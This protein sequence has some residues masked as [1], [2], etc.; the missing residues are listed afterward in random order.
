MSTYLDRHGHY[1]DSIVVR[2]L[3]VQSARKGDD[4]FGEATS[5]VALA[6][7]HTI[8]GEHTA[9]LQSLESA[10]RIVDDL[11]HKRGQASVLYHLAGLEMH[12]GNTAA[13]LDLYRRCLSRVREMEL[14]EALAWVH[15]RYGAA[16]RATEQYG[17]ALEHLREAKSFALRV[18]DQSALSA[19]LVEI[20]AVYRDLG[21]LATSSIYCGQALDIAESI[22]DLELTAQICTTLAAISKDRGEP[23][24][25]MTFARQAVDLCRNTRNVIG[26]AHARNVLGDIEFANGDAEEAALDW[27]QAAQL[28]EYVGNIPSAAAARAKLDNIPGDGVQV[29]AVRPYGT[30]DKNT[31]SITKAE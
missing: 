6:M 4:S 26:E 22:P 11:G 20:A 15:C 14:D 13:A 1:E 5:L 23:R 7:V 28:Y 24:D 2:K 19:A 8:V 9:A 18:A 30:L 12:R 16:L 25:A 17:E 3:A 29:P 31:P 10:R 21:D 27:Q